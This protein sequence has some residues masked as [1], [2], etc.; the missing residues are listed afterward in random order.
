VSSTLGLSNRDQQVR[1]TGIGASEV[2][3][4]LGIVPGAID[5]YAR[6][7]GEAPDFE[8]ND[9]TEFGHRIED[10]IG[11]GYVARHQGVRIYKPGTLRHPR[12][13][14]ALATPDR[15][16]APPGVGRPAREAWLDLLEIKT[17]FFSGSEYGEAGTGEIPEKHLV[18]VAW[19][20]A[21]AD[22]PH[23]TL[24]A[25]VNG[26]YREYP[27]K[28]D[29]ELEGL[30]LQAV[31][32]F[33]VDQVLARV[34]PAIDGS[35]A[36]EAYLR[37]RHPKD[38]APPL[39]RTPEAEEVVQ[40]LRLAKL[41]TAEAEKAEA[42]AKQQLLALVG[43][44]AGIDGL[45]TYRANKPSEKTDWEAVAREL[46]APLEVVARNTHTK[47]GSRVLRLTKEK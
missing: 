10:V 47:P 44:A 45:C 5:V 39:P 13:D 12:F 1:A 19:Q 4:I 3:P 27:V 42:E 38:V 11:D 15:V 26:S 14:W 7:V 35:E 28:R 29:P 33:W 18:Q 32:K 16:V 24:V 9:L 40:R 8:G 22:M 43:D 20:L 25:L 41:A 46:N 23:A 17:V 6:K 37:R 36:Y 21:V 34:P 30:L 31:E 2:A